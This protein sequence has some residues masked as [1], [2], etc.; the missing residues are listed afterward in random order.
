MNRGDLY[1]AMRKGSLKWIVA[2]AVCLLCVA[3]AAVGNATATRE[4]TA[5]CLLYA[6][7]AASGTPGESYQGSLMAQDRVLSYRD[8]AL[9]DRV[10]EKTI[11]SLGLDMSVPE[12][13]SR[14]SVETQ[15]QSVAMDVSVTGGS[16]AEAVQLSREVC[17]QLVEAARWGDSPDDGG[18][19]IVALRILQE[20]LTPEGPSSPN[21]G[22][23]LGIGLLAG[24]LLA[25]AV[26][27]GWGR[28]ERL[29]GEGATG[30][31]DS[32]TD[33]GGK[34]LQG[35]EPKTDELNGHSWP[36]GHSPLDREDARS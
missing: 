7:P 19:P 29:L 20:P 34:H 30:S 12:L 11:A 25:A 15:P 17:Q 3:A 21:T 35:D 10:S 28:V 2:A 1:R 6:S 13:Q 14:I 8:L 5:V 26:V 36:N 27:I 18:G 31:G 33:S 9:S 24:L 4:Y 23:N 22:R 16:A 32:E